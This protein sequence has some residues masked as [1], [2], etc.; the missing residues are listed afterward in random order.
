MGYVE[1]AEVDLSAALPSVD[2]SCIL[3]PASTVCDEPALMDAILRDAD[4]Y[5]ARLLSTSGS[6]PS[7]GVVG[8]IAAADPVFSSV[9]L[10]VKDPRLAVPFFARLG[11]SVVAKTDV[12]GERATKWY[13]AVSE[14]RGDAL[15]ARS[16][17]RAPSV[18]V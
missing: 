16:A 5:H 17:L 2:P 12:P 11:L 15:R 8:P 14:Q 13:M 9:M 7:S 1:I 3:R 6:V 18:I 4:G 10:H